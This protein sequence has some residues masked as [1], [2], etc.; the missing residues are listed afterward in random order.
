[1]MYKSQLQKL[2]FN[3]ALVN[4]CHTNDSEDLIALILNLP[5]LYNLF[6]SVGGKLNSMISGAYFTMLVPP[7]QH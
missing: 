5:C 6:M 3:I 4:V 7:I 2:Y 1:M